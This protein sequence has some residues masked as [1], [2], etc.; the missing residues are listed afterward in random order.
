MIRNVI[1]AAG[2]SGTKVGLCGQAPSYCLEFPAFLV[3]GGI[4]SIAESPVSFFAVKQSV[5]LAEGWEG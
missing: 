4:D 2:K 1:R 5:A 3:D